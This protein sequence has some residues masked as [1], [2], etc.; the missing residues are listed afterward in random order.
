MYK[1]SSIEEIKAIDNQK[2]FDILKDFPKQV[3]EAVNIGENSNG[4]KNKAGSK[5]FA[6]LGM[7]GSAI[8]G[9]ILASYLSNTPGADELIINTYRNYRLPGS[10]TPDTNII[11]SSYSGGT[12]ETITAFNSVI[13]YYYRWQNR[14]NC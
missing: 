7:G 12:E 5:R 13:V 4:F 8:G 11:A 14:R 10:V 9:D 3:I 6:V 2:M 1:F